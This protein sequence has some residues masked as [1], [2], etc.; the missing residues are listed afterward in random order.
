MSRPLVVLIAASELLTG[1]RPSFDDSELLAFADAEVLRALETISLRRPA[2]VVLEHAFANTS[3]GAALVNR[4]KADPALAHVLVEV[5]TGGTASPRI[6]PAA[7]DVPAPVAPPQPLDTWGTRRA[8]RVIVRDGIDI[9]IDGATVRLVN[10]SIVGAQVLSTGVLK[11][12]QRVRVSLVDELGSIRLAAVIAWARFEL[13][14]RGQPSARYRAGL[15]F[16]DADTA[17]VGAFA[18][19]NG[20]PA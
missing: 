15:D 18:E 13:P 1:L 3:R 6:E 11:P 9:V 17:A 10:L 7:V 4:L 5:T 2:R 19:R 12:N 8:P 14:H 20:R 16:L